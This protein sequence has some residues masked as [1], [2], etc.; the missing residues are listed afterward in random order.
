MP[1]HVPT[2]YRAT[3]SPT[4]NG[5]IGNSTAITMGSVKL[6]ASK[7]AIARHGKGGDWSRWSWGC[8]A[9]ASALRHMASWPDYVAAHS[10]SQASCPLASR[11]PKLRPPSAKFRQGETTYT[12]TPS[13][14]RAAAP[15]RRRRACRAC[16]T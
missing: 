15:F 11:R 2:S 1:A 7:M 8:V 4:M 12:Y 10:A 5:A 16:P 6:H 13:D 14:A 3:Q 9:A